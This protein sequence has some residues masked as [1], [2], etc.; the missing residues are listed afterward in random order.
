MKLYG[1]DKISEIYKTD[2]HMKKSVFNGLDTIS[3]MPSCFILMES[4]EL[5]AFCRC[6]FHV[7]DSRYLGM[8]RSQCIFFESD[9]AALFFMFAE[10]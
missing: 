1:M 8:W 7:T 2:D 4:N 6:R 9:S 10:G 5:A 3:W